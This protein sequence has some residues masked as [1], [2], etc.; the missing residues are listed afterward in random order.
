MQVIS[1]APGKAILFGEHAVVYG[2]P[3]IAMALDKRAQVKVSKNTD[4]KIS[5][6]IRDLGIKGH[7]DLK[8]DSIK[9][10]SPKKGILKYV[11]SSLKKVHEGSGLD[12]CIDVNVPIGGGLG[13][14][15]AVTVALIAAVSKYN[16][17]DLGKKDIAG[18]A[19][20]VELEVQNSASTL[21]TTI[22]TYGGLIYLEKNAKDIISLDINHDIPVVIGYTDSRGN[23]GKLVES[24]KMRKECYPKIINPIIDS[25]ELITNEAKHAILNNDKNRI[26]ELMNIN[27]GLLDALGVNTMELSNMVYTARSA[28]AYGSKITGAGGGGSILSFCPDG[29]EKVISA[30][31]KTENAFKADISKEGVKIN[32]LD[33]D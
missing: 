20:E 26:G 1:S 10:D 32:V 30:L 6:N 27:H 3:A 23:T 19:H 28:G 15:A 16:D 21:D 22:S 5:I 9:S 18:F 29:T 24:V 14:S 13:S 11:L 17:M 12:L 25:I 7:I 8:D 33:E 4:K 31:K 2:K